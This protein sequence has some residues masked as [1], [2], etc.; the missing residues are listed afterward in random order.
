MDVTSEMKV[1]PFTSEAIYY[2]E[3]IEE[4]SYLMDGPVYLSSVP[5]DHS[6]ELDP[7]AF[8][9]VRVTYDRDVALD[10]ASVQLMQNGVQV[11]DL[12]ESTVVSEEDPKTVE[13]RSARWRMANT[14]WW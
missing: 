13:Y 3:T 10:I 2:D 9:E 5:E 8:N 4:M 6:F 1:L 11:A 7:S 12:Y 14:S